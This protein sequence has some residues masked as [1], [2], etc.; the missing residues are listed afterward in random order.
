M[1]TP[2]KVQLTLPEA[3]ARMR[4]ALDQNNLPV[5]E[6]MGRS[7]VQSVPENAETL[8]LLGI[9]LQR[10]GQLTNAIE[11]LKK[12]AKFA[13]HNGAIFAN[14]CEM[15]RMNGDLASAVSTGKTAVKIAPNYAISHCNLGM[16]LLDME[17]YD[18]SLAALQRAIEI[19]PNFATAHNNIGTAL[20]KKLDFAGAEKSYR[21]ALQHDPDEANAHNN[22]I[23][24]LLETDQSQLAIDLAKQ[25]LTKTPNDTE[26]YRSI[27]RGY[28]QLE[29]LD[30]AERSFRAALALKPDHAESMLGLAEVFQKKNHPALAFSES[31]KAA[32][33]DPTSAYAYQQMGH[34]QADLGNV[35]KAFEYLEKSLSLDANFV[36]ALLSR[37]YLHMENG[38]MDLANLD[39]A[40]VAEIKPDSV[41]YL[42][43]S[44]R[45]EKIKQGDPRITHLE[46][47][48]AESTQFRPSKAIAVHYALAKCY[49]DI[50]SFDKAFTQF[51]FGAKVKRSTLNYDAKSHDEKIDAIIQLFD[52]NLINNLRQSADMSTQPIF[53]LG[54]P[55]SGTTLTES[56]IA[57]HPLVYGA[58]ELNHL[59]RL[60]RTE[61]VQNIDQMRSFLN[62]Q[63]TAIS[64]HIA[65]YVAQLDAHSPGMMR[66]TDKMPSNFLLLGLINAL[67][68]N[69][70]IIHV[71]RDAVDTCVSC[72]TRLFERSQYHSYDLQELG[73]YYNGYAR[74]MRHWQS[75]L[76]TN[77]FHTISYEALVNDPETEARA[78]I[79]YCGLTWDDACLSFHTA[80]RRVRTASVTQVRNP[81]YSTSVAKWKQYEKHLAPLL[82]TLNLS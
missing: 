3:I 20:R 65:K 48:A 29:N 11:M 80:K 52:I 28:L 53:V 33:I 71:A 16:A 74:L 24:L 70:K 25:R 73:Q 46:R 55:R 1:N 67:L 79:A 42:F 63:P 58:G 41:E 32:L 5:A 50:A 23:S 47:L 51:Q 62:G 30:D 72:F 66:I 38:D 43:S 69:S 22:L 68:P 40:R 19:N 17:N 26:L 31:E 37:G 35:P 61:T 75:V 34:C 81:M 60:F 12:A 10:M 77:S 49:E 36:P 7:I 27:G 57:S 54:M 15:Q 9:T 45:M 78:L 64:Q 14:L 21:T 8:H 59:Q 13:A 6:K 44:V 4:R 56:I 2:A 18:G 82:Q 76:P 39:F